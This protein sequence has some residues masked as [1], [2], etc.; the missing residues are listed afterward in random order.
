MYEPRPVSEAAPIGKPLMP[1]ALKPKPR[2]LTANPATAE[3]VEWLDVETD[4][5]STGE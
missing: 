1:A 3:A 2:L 5:P 4:V